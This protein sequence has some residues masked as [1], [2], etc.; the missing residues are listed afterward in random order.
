MEDIEII[1]LNIE[2][3]RRLLQTKLG[4][5]ERRT[6]RQLLAEQEAALAEHMAERQE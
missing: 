5:N 1:R 4:E 3:F 2:R 6:I